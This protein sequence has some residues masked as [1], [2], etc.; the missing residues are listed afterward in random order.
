MIAAQSGGPN[1]FTSLQRQTVAALGTLIGLIAQQNELIRD[2]QVRTGTRR[3][4]TLAMP[5]NLG[6]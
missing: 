3:T 2:G 6:G 4:I 1:S 5:G